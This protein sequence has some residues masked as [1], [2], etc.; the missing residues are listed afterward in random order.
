MRHRQGW[1]RH[2]KRPLTLRAETAR[3]NAEQ[4][5][6]DK[7][8]AER[9]HFWDRIQREGES[10][11]SKWESERRGF[12]AIISEL[13][14]KQGRDLARVQQHIADRDAEL[15]RQAEKYRAELKQV[16]ADLDRQKELTQEQ[17]HLR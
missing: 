17:K 10:T 7:V 4:E 13:K 8:Q 2:L 5:C 12:E 3:V 16:S 15:D 14:A 1:K 6:M 11:K 9:R